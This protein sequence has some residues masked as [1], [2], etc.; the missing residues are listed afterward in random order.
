MA[1]DQARGGIRVGANSCNGEILLVPATNARTGKDTH[2]L[3]QSLP[4][5]NGRTCVGIYYKELTPD[6]P[7][8]SVGLAEDWQPGLEIVFY[9]SAY[10]TMT[11]QHDG[12][13]G[14]FLEQAPTDYSLFYQPLTLESILYGLA[15]ACML[16]AVA[17]WFSCS[18]CSLAEAARSIG[19]SSARKSRMQRGRSIWTIMITVKRT[20]R[21]TR[22]SRMKLRLRIR[23]RMQNKR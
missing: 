8:T 17:L 18:C 16:G 14:F 1:S 6:T 21:N 5:G 19:S 15:A 3:L 12:R 2:I 22:Q 9:E 11:L 13:I 10:S 20:T 4:T 7:H 23:H